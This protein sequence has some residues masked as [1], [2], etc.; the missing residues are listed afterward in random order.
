MKKR[1][2]NLKPPGT[3]LG[4]D[5]ADPSHIWSEIFIQAYIVQEA[6]KAGLTLA[7]GMEQGKRSKLSGARAKASGMA[8]GEP[9][10]RFYLPMGQIKLIELKTKDGKLN[11]AQKLR[12]PKLKEL[13]YAVSVVY[14][15]S[16]MDGWLQVKEILGNV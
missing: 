15:E 14:A 13:G 16:P 9:D 7:A 3:F 1:P 12:I 4:K 11:D 5:P 6:L 8:A 2:P 10:L